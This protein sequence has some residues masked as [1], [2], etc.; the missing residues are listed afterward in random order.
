MQAH[1]PTLFLV[2]ITV[3]LILAGVLAAAGY[4][5][6]TELILW[7]SSLVLHSLAFI[8]YS[9]RGQISDL[10]S[11]VVANI[12]MS[13]IFAVIAEGFFL[14][15]R[16]R[17]PRLLIW[18]PVFLV[19]LLFIWLLD[20]FQARVM[21]GG[22]I[23]GLQCLYLAYITAANRHHIHGRGK[24]IFGASAIIEATMLCY[25]AISLL[26]GS[27]VSPFLAPTQVNTITY[28]VSVV[29]MIL[30]V[31]GLLLMTWERDERL[32]RRREAELEMAMHDTEQ[33]RKQL[34]TTFKTANDGIYILDERGLLIDANDAFLKMHGF[35]K[36][37]IGRLHI[38]DWNAQQ[39]QD[40][41][42][43]HLQ[44]ILTS[45]HKIM[46]ET[47]HYGR[48]GKIISVEV[49]ANPLMLDDKKLI[50]CASRDITERKKL[51]E[52][53]TAQ[54]HYD[55]LTGLNNRR[56]FVQL[57]EN[58]LAR[59]RRSHKPLSLLMMDIDNFKRI[60][61][62]YG[63][64]VGDHV[65]RHLADL[66]LNT[67][68]EIDIVGRLG[69]EEFG[70]ILPET[71]IDDAVEVAERLRKNVEKTELPLAEHAAI[72][73]TISIGVAR[74]MGQHIKL[75]DLIMAA[76]KALYAAKTAGKNKVM[77]SR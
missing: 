60:N 41:I 32:L 58:E 49:N 35:D 57:A 8:L 14:F 67:V 36:T 77:T 34:E 29:S 73:Y 47:L 46:F 23:F 42:L 20:N 39:N 19:G 75:D 65:L 55:F 54:A 2:I 48:D 5:K 1:I 9:L 72:R 43:A 61:D 69:G 45:H 4:R 21:F 6:K 12:C 40:V 26:T 33:K 44:K 7:S 38:Q 27:Q 17:P 16:K 66:C 15:L 51:Q 30:L 53:L 11:I 13:S 63:H 31:V 10:L 56:N 37:A 76:D 28:L 70:I 71:Q 64:V 74:I 25:R 62:T 59:D 24:Y 3:S 68:R 52:Q 22:L 18:A 50:Y